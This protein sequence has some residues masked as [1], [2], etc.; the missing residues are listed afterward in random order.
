MNTN[1]SQFPKSAVKPFG[2][3]EEGDERS[4]LPS[5]RKVEVSSSDIKADK[6]GAVVSHPLPQKGPFGSGSLGSVGD[7]DELKSS[8]AAAVR[9]AANRASTEFVQKA[10]SGQFAR[11]GAAE[12]EKANAGRAKK[13]IK[14]RS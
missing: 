4:T 10:K 3:M 5:G 14:I 8:P 9:E 13:T 7:D 1:E 2:P 11:E 12:V 6:Y